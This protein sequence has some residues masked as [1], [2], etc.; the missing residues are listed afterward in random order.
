L[1]EVCDLT[2]LDAYAGWNTAGN[3]IGS[4]I[5]QAVLPHN[6]S[7]LLERFID[8][9]GY[10]AVVRQKIN[11]K[12]N[13]MELSPYNLGSK[14]D[15][16]EKIMVEEMKAWLTNFFLNLPLSTND[17]SLSY[18]WRRTFEIDCDIIVP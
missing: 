1:K 17:L 10:Q 9:V 16:V 13:S 15:K 5:A 11:E 14:K 4:A 2:G 18:P 12:V 8:D 7:F 6:K 3:S